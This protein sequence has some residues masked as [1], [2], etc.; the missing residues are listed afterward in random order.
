MSLKEHHDT[1]RSERAGVLAAAAARPD[2]QFAAPN[3]SAHAAISAVARG[4]MALLDRSFRV[5]AA[6]RAYHQL[7]PAKF[8]SRPFCEP[9]ASGWSKAALKALDGTA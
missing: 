6:N 4:P 5:T 3:L 7:F 1:D 8:A 2:R 9:T